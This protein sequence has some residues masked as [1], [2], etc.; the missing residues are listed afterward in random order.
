MEEPKKPIFKK[1]QLSETFGNKKQAW[2][3][4]KQILAVEKSLPWNANDVNCKF[5][6]AFVIIFF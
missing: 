4:L 6:G 2:R 3:S 1:C 5:C